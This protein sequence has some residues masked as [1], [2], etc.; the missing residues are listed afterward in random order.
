MY[1]DKRHWERLGTF[2]NG[3][4][5]SSLLVFCLFVFFRDHIAEA[6]LGGV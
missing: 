2:T 6:L 1:S 5:A 3:G 4:N